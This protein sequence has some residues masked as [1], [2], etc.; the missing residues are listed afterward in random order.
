MITKTE[1]NGSISMADLETPE[2]D[3]PVMTRRKDVAA[4][5]PEALELERLKARID[6]A[7]SLEPTANERHCL[8]CFNRGRNAVI[9]AILDPKE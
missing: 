1:R 4:K 5:T 2:T 7:K 6:A 8:D 3:Q 9:R